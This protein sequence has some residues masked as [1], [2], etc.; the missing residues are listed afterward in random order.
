MNAMLIAGN[1]YIPSV[2][3][4]AHWLRHGTLWLEAHEH[5]QKRSWRN[6]TWIQGKEKPVV[7]SIPLQKGKNESCPVRDVRIAYDEPWPH[8]HLQALQTTY[9]KTP[10]FEEVFPSLEILLTR[11]TDTLWELNL[12]LLRELKEM[13][14]TIGTIRL[15]NAYL[16]SYEADVTDL[17]KG[18]HCGMPEGIAMDG[19]PHYEQIQRI[20][21]SFQPNLSIVDALFHLGPETIPYLHRYSHFLYPIV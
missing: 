18:I 8:R 6:R 11:Q 20:G 7:L 4:F 2:A 15:T 5:Y 1:Q 14:R 19:M 17:R 12:H 10:F 9:G 16:R 21:L 3:Y 13:M